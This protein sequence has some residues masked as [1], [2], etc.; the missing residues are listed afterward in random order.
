MH[1]QTQEIFYHLFVK[2]KQL[3]DGDGATSVHC[4]SLRRELW[5]G[6][7]C[8]SDL[9]PY[10]QHLEPGMACTEGEG[11]LTCP[12]GPLMEQLHKLVQGTG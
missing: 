4:V 5:Q 9:D 6:T 10:D 11:G 2:W 12:W 3:S 1:A 8:G 7:P